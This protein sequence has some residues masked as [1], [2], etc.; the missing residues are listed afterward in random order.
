MACKPTTTVS[1]YRN[2]FGLI[3]YTACYVLGGL[4]ALNLIKNEM[5]VKELI[6]QLKKCDQDKVVVLTEP[7]GKGWDNIGIVIENVS[8]VKITMDG[9][10]L[11]HE[12]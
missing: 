7:D 12:S 1:N 2:S 9:N 5:T 3:S 4:S 10:G 11:F 6:E 8:T